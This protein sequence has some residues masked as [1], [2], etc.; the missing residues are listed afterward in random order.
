M[1]L[2][3]CGKIELPEVNEKEQIVIWAWDESFNIKALK[4]A[5]KSFRKTHKNVDIEI[6][7]MAQDDVISKLNTSLANGDYTG[8]PN[9][10]LIEDYVVQG[11]L[12][13]YP[14][15]FADLSDIA[16]AKDFVAYK[17]SVNEIDGKLYGIPFDSG[18]AALFYRRD[19]IEAAGYTTE[20][21]EDLTW[22]KYIEIGK[23]VKEKTGKDML[24][25]NPNDLGQIRLK[26][27]KH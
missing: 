26:I 8:L 10:V 14:E 9:I 16:D 1:S 21:M 3:S 13:E 24:T 7:A 18:V 20:D 2:S 27:I 5:K 23:A 25:L 19:M 15:E 4:E 22:D 6:V 11:Y 12:M 17:T